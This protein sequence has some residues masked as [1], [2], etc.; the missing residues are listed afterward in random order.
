MSSG[1]Q[2]ALA[3][4]KPTVIV[5]GATSGMGLAAA[6]LL[7]Q[8]GF[9]VFGGGRRVKEPHTDVAGIGW[10]PL[11]VRDEASC[12]AFVAWVRTQATRI[13]HVVHSAGY[14]LAGAVED[15]ELAQL[16]DQMDTNFFGAVLMARAVLP[17][18]REQRGGTLLFVSSLVGLIAAPF[19]GYYSASKFAVEGLAEALRYEARPF[20]VYVSLLEPGD[21]QTGMT[22]ARI[23]LAPK[24]PAYDGLR[25][26]AVEEMGRNEQKG[27][28]SSV[29]AEK[30]LDILRTP[31]PRLRYRVGSDSVWFPRLRPWVPAGLFEWGVRKAFKL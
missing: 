29:A 16:R 31:R 9:Q 4:R 12:G 21:F 28:P 3:T 22:A 24:L 1:A 14:A 13:D 27:P 2:Q 26:R 19:H 23:S 20:G 8:R 5:T 7:Q 25:E 10:H 15:G 11:D 30:I 6:T 17:V 18:L